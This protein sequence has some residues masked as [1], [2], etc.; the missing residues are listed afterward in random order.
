M[1]KFSDANAKIKSLALVDAIKPYL[2]KKRKVY[3]LDL[4]SGVSCPYAKDCLSKAKV[5]ADGRRKIQDGP[6][7][8]FRCFSAS[9]EVLFTNLWKL[10]DGNFA[11]LR[12]LSTQQI[13]DEILN[14]MP[15]NLGVC[16][17]HVGGDFFNRRCFDAWLHI[18][19]LMP[20]KLFYAYTKS[21]PFWLK[22]RKEL[23]K[24]PNFVLTASYG[25]R[26]DNLIGKHR[27]R[28]A[29]V[30]ADQATCEKIYAENL[31]TWNGLEIDHD[32]SHAA[33]PSKRKQHFALLIHG[34][35]PAGSEAGKSVRTLKGKGSYARNS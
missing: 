17:L 22:R 29:K 26:C 32:D 13:V 23:R 5:Q 31:S 7:T 20:S 33:D 35:Q 18:A 21:L 28:H 30:I 2:T 3:S 24:T 12:Q 8:V 15:A 6:D 1:L 14:A 4:L 9:Q 34:P 11:H 19:K 10:R 27:L 25:G 16:R